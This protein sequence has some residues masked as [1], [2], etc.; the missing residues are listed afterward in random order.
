ML[1]MSYSA[2]IFFPKW[3]KSNNEATISWD[4]TGY[5]MYLPALFIYH[6]LK[7]C[8]FKDS[9][10]QKY[11]PTPDFSQ[12]F[13]HKNSGNYVM[14]YSSGQAIAMLPWFIA[15]H[16]WASNSSIYPADGF[17]IPYQSSIGIGMFLY[18]LFGLFLLRKILLLYF[19]DK[20][21]AISLILLVFGT[22]YLNYSSIDQAMTHNTLFTVYVLIIY[23]TIVF[24]KNPSKKHIILIGLLCG[25]ATLIRPTEIISLSIPLLWGLSSKKDILE[26][27]KFIKSRIPDVFLLCICFFVVV[28]IQ[29]I[30]W[31]WVANEWLVYSYQDQGFS[32]LHPHIKDYLLSYRCGWWRYCPMMILPFIG[33]IPFVKQKSNTIPV[34]FLI[35]VAFYLV[36]AWDVWDYGSTS[37]RA[38][39]QYYPFL[40]FPLAALVKSVRTK[41]YLVIPFTLLSII[42]IYLNI[43]WTY[44]AHK[45]KIQVSEVSKQYYWK[46]LGRWSSSEAD[47]KLIDNIDSYDGVIVNPKI[48]Y[49]N[50]F[51]SDS[52]ENIV[53]KEGN[54]KI[55]LS[56]DMQNSKTYTFINDKNHQQWLRVSALFTTEAKEWNFWRQTQ[57]IL[58][59][60]NGDTEVKSNMIRVY[61]FLNDNESKLVYLDARTPQVWTKASIEFWH[62]L[63]DKNLWIDDLEVISFDEQ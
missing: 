21:V 28:M 36:T 40:M 48:I 6:D 39:V 53:Q 56:K 55:W 51:D 26:R 45:G 62:A 27:F 2:F 34:V 38:M 4:V 18:A 42:F 30:Y 35:F 41:Y 19:P 25:F 12:A 16:I 37:G 50:H 17:S 52:S 23:Q 11:H 32:W 46:T 61:R 3:Q 20:V 33:L 47:K 9:V 54:R 8:S 59:F 22:N 57:F 15:G 10:I 31:K 60:Y 1:F 44:N 63:G 29:A 5:Y 13:L 7:K 14:K 43:W 49:E 24:Y 58:K